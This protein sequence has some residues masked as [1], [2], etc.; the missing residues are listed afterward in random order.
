MAGS[1]R[2]GRVTRRKIGP[3]A[4]LNRNVRTGSTSV[5]HK[6]GKHTVTQSSKGITRTTK[7]YDSSLVSFT[8]AQPK[9]ARA[10]KPPRLRMPKLPKI[11]FRKP[12]GYKPPKI[13]DLT[14]AS[15][16]SRR[17]SSGGSHV[18]TFRPGGSGSA[19]GWLVVSLLGAVFRRLLGR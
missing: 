6:Q 4:W 9:K 7:L 12:K 17:Q 15:R 2:R 14:K 5:T 10:A 11:N 18:Q 13:K 3:N 16:P 8:P 1:H 19:L